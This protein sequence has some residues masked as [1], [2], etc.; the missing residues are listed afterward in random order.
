MLQQIAERSLL[1]EGL[2]GRAYGMTAL[3]LGWAWLLFFVVMTP[4]ILVACG[5]AASWTNGRVGDP[6]YVRSAGTM[7]IPFL[8]ILAIQWLMTERERSTALVLLCVMPVLMIAGLKELMGLKWSTTAV[9][10]GLL[11]VAVP[12][13]GFVLRLITNKVEEGFATAVG[14]DAASIVKY[15]KEHPDEI[16][17]I[18]RK[19]GLA[20]GSPGTRPPGA[21]RWSGPNQ[22]MFGPGASGT[23]Y[24]PPPQPPDPM[25]GKL[26]PLIL[27]LQSA[28]ADA[29]ST[30]REE[31]EPR[32]AALAAEVA[33][34]PRPA[35]Q[36]RLYEEANRL[37][38]ELSAAVAK[39]PSRVPPPELFAAVPDRPLSVTPAAAGDYASPD[40]AFRSLVLRPLKG[41]KLDLKGYAAREKTQR[42]ILRE[43][44]P[45]TLELT[46]EPLSDA[47]QQRPWMAELPAVAQIASEQNLFTE[48]LPTHEYS[49]A[50]ADMISG[51]LNGLSWTRVVQK[52]SAS[53]IRGASYV[54][55]LPDGWLVAG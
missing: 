31:L 32:R 24:S 48:T 29:R 43:S 8:M 3:Q 42:W 49:G 26:E 44:P 28:M 40:I 53:M 17:E 52:N 39:A 16:L 10:A 50:R 20:L 41:A 11:V 25:V 4:I 23:P 34:V 7:S 14:M 36:S 13:S 5:L 38:A 15:V 1:P 12:A 45:V 18:R 54:A 19:Q 33:A 9:A 55:R 51:R 47:R 30:V 6:A 21:P 2:M 46:L 22:P 27:S 37:A 35:A